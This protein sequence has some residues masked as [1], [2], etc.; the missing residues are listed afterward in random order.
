MQPAAAL[1]VNPQLD[2]LVV[3]VP[4]YIAIPYETGRGASEHVVVNSGVVE[5]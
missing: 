4:I 2:R 5:A 1:F 3:L